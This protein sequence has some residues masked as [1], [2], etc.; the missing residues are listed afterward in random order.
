MLKES[1]GHFSSKVQGYAKDNKTTDDK[2][3]K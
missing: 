3:Y 2:L 1:I